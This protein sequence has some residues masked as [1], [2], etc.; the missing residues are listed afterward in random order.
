M[1]PPV[2]NACLPDAPPPARADAVGG[3]AGTNAEEARPLKKLPAMR[4]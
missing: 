3:A 1:Y 2:V 4:P